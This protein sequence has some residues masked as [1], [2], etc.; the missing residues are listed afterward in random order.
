MVQH[1]IIGN[2]LLAVVACLW[3]PAWPRQAPG[4]PMAVVT[5][6]LE[7]LVSTAGWST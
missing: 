5:K 1:D 4:A 7:L 6:T 2:V 3:R